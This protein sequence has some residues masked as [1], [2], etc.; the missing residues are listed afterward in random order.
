M[1]DEKKAQLS[2]SYFKIEDSFFL[3][4][5]LDFC[6]IHAANCE[7]NEIN[8]ARKEGRRSVGLYLLTLLHLYNKKAYREV[9]DI[10][11]SVKNAPKTKGEI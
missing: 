2:L 4:D 9:L 8:L 10:N 11:E 3:K 6:G 1:S 7:S 5:L